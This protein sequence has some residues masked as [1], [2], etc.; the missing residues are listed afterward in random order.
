MS[1]KLLMRLLSA[2]RCDKFRTFYYRLYQTDSISSSII[3]E[4][5]P[6]VSISQIKQSLKQ[7]QIITVEGH[8]CIIIEC[9]ICDFEKLKK[10]KIYINKTTGK[11]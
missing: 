5:V 9:P 4:P 7:K 1:L 10:A 2:G 3:N 6:G 11:K 8:A